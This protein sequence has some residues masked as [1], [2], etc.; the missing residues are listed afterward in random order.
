MKVVNNSN[1]ISRSG[2][3]KRTAKMKDGGCVCTVWKKNSEP[4]YENLWVVLAKSY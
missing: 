3:L 1:E 4:L 2:A